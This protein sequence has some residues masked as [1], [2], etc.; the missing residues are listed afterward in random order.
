MTA[1]PGDGGEVNR[2]ASDLNWLKVPMTVAIGAWIVVGVLSLSG[3]IGMSAETFIDGA[4]VV[5]LGCMAWT[6][7]WGYIR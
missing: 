4:Q 5:I 2:I 1:D 7:Y 6:I 3:I